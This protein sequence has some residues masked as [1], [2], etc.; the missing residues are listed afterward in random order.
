MEMIGDALEGILRVVRE[1]RAPLVAALWALV[2]FVV[3][4]ILVRRRQDNFGWK[5]GASLL[6]FGGAAGALLWWSLQPGA[7]YYFFVDEVAPKE[8]AIRLHRAP[9]RVH[10]KVVVGSLERQKGTDVYQFWMEGRRERPSA[11]IQ[12]HYI[13]K[14]PDTL[15]SGSEIVATGMLSDDGSVNIERDG[16][17][18]M[19]PGKYDGPVT[20]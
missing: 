10:G 9:I 5:L 7:S 4:A 12:A 14:L 6:A 20:R 17:W 3:A 16:I 13:G 8:L 1:T 19:C 2:A 11:V 15:R 18:T